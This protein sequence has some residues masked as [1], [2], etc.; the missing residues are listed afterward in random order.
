[1]SGLRLSKEEFE[2]LPGGGENRILYEMPMGLQVPTLPTGP[3]TPL[4]KIVN[5]AK[6]TK[7]QDAF[8]NTWVMIGGDRNFWQTEYKFHPDR[9][10]RFDFANVD[11]MIAVEVNGGQWTKSGHSTGRGLQRD[12]EKLNLAQSLGWTV[13]VLTTSMLHKREAAGHVGKIMSRT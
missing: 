1:M 9:R 4:Q 7:L 3:K 12:A 5:A 13:Y 10:Y 11:R 8:Y 6:R 2:A